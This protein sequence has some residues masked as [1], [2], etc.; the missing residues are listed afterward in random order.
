LQISV[1]LLSDLGSTLGKINDKSETNLH[2]D[3]AHP[4]LARYFIDDFVDDLTVYF[5]T[6][7]LLVVHFNERCQHRKPA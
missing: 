7:F 4:S 1:I 6:F 2:H 3:R 5:A